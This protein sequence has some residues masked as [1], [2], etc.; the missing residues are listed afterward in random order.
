MGRLG[1]DLHH[2]SK[3]NVSQGNFSNLYWDYKQIK[4]LLDFRLEKLS[5]LHVE[6]IEQHGGPEALI[7]SFLEYPLSEIQRKLLKIIVEEPG[8]S[9]Q[10]YVGLLQVHYNTFSELFGDLSRR[11][12]SL[13]NARIQ[14]VVGP[15]RLESSLPYQQQLPPTNLPAQWTSFI[16]REN[17]VAAIQALISQHEIRLVSLIGP[18]GTG[19]T[20]LAIEVAAGLRARF[21]HG[22]FFIALAPLQD[23]S[24]I[25]T[26]INK[27]LGISE[28]FG[29]THLEH[30]IGYLQDKQVLLVLD[31]F[32]HVIDSAPFITQLLT[33]SPGLFVL[34]TSR[35]VLNIY[36]EYVVDIHPL[37]LPQQ[38]QMIVSE[39]LFRYEATR[40]FVERSRMQ[41]PQQQFHTQ[42]QAQI[43]NTICHRL[44]GLPLAI[45]LVAA[46][47]RTLSVKE[48]LD[49]LETPLTFV[50][51]G[52]R[53]LPPRQQTLRGAIEWSYSLLDSDEQDLFV[54]MG[55]FAGGCT[56]E[57]I[58]GMFGL[59]Q[60]REKVQE[61]IASLLQKSLIKQ[62]SEKNNQ[63]RL[64]MLSTIRQYALQ[65]LAI[66]GLIEEVQRQYAEYY[67]LMAER[68]EPELRKSRQIEYLDFLWTELDN[69]QAVL[70]W[71]LSS[72][73]EELALRLGAALWQFWQ[74]K[75]L[76]RE[77][78]TPLMRALEQ[79]EGV[80]NAIKA[81]AL[82]VAGNLAANDIDFVTAKD[83]LEKSVRLSKD[84]QSKQMYALAKRTLAKIAVS[85]NKISDARTYVDEIMM[86]HAELG[87]KYEIAWTLNAKAQV[88]WKTKDVEG[89]IRLCLQSLSIFEEIGDLFGIAFSHLYMGLVYFHEKD[90]DKASQAFG[91]SLPLCKKKG[92]KV[93]SAWLLQ[94]LGFTY[95]YQGN[96][97]REALFDEALLL[98]KETDRRS[99]TASC[100]VGMA[101]IAA[102]TDR[103]HRAIQLL[104]AAEALLEK[105][106]NHS[107][108]L[109]YL[110]VRAEAEQ[111]LDSDDTLALWHRGRSMT[112]DEMIHYALYQKT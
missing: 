50:T 63:T 24:L 44:D 51:G 85:E 66:D 92:D 30:L 19:K 33:A 45:E 82:F 60:K 22:V 47:I 94:F 31:N 20:R 32:E 111:E 65:R 68:L 102:K 49:R 97:E 81:K 29:K 58:I 79:A 62:V 78:R 43:V 21:K 54:H 71:C 72:R 84:M 73:Q 53:D 87:D 106:P 104:G 86:I 108:P 3:A 67:V 107:I 57:T 6:F 7:R 4:A 110:D 74:Q 46:R 75:G 89:T 28:S 77:G 98:Y 27:T 76:L 96:Y 26:T 56:I 93:N 109:Q 83:L 100:L 16:G 23:A 48:I 8:E 64:H 14:S 70:V 103:P 40:L 17:E 91:K 11:L 55:I 18:G 25:V 59:E 1:K 34:V 80:S 35:E 105:Y 9:R 38:S 39:D 10:Y 88:V 99:D 41:S 52:P 101:A 42:E 61:Q 90:Y 95:Y 12:A 13:L 15:E 5:E 112:L 69:L 2:R 37:S 36:G